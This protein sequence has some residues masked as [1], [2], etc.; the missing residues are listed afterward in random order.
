MK[1][2]EG[3]AYFSRVVSY[4]RN[5]FMKCTADFGQEAAEKASSEIG[6]RGVE[7]E[8]AEAQVAD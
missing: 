8:A 6:E 3:T 2:K 4:S 5:M 7:P 1:W